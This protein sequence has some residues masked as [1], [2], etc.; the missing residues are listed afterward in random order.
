MLFEQVSGTS[1]M[2]LCCWSVK[3][4]EEHQRSDSTTK[5]DSPK[6][7]VSPASDDLKPDTGKLE[8]PP[9]S[10]SEPH[11]PGKPLDKPQLTSL[12]CRSG[13]SDSSSSY[14]TP[15][16]SRRTVRVLQAQ[17]HTH[18]AQITRME[19]AEK[20][21]MKQHMEMKETILGLTKRVEKLETENKCKDTATPD[22]EELIK[23]TASQLPQNCSVST[24]VLVGLAKH[25]TQWKFLAR[26]LHLQES[27]IQQIGVNFSNDVQEQSYQMLLKWKLTCSNASYHTLGEAVREEFGET[28]YC[29]YVE[30]VREEEVVVSG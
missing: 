5:E 4:P 20:E 21:R 10:A 29:D 27:D 14:H 22:R 15:P 16:T 12:S 18:R 28:L 23:N 2:D 13:F 17:E 6:H 8:R 26:R 9:R 19:I 11:K 7:H 25:V 3:K 1:V 24:K 30:M